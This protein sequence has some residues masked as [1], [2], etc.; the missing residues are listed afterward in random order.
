MSHIY[1][2]E[3][4]YWEIKFY[5]HYEYVV[6]FDIKKYSTRSAMPFRRNYGKTIQQNKISESLI[7]VTDH[8]KW[9][10]LLIPTDFPFFQ[11][12]DN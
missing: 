1:K 4:N 2:T 10:V 8:L 6:L 5:K 3:A 12:Y 7:A 11:L 9:T